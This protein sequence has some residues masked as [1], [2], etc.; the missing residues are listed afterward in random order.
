MDAGL[1]TAFKANPLNPGLVALHLLVTRDYPIH[2]FVS[3]HFVLLIKN[4]AISQCS[5]AAAELTVSLT[6]HESSFHESEEHLIVALDRTIE[7][8]IIHLLKVKVATTI[9]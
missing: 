3:Y 6:E 7:Y 5:H 2:R 8:F 9:F 1:V 4:V